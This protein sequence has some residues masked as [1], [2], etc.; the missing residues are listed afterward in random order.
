MDLTIP[1]VCKQL[2]CKDI[3]VT[4]FYGYR[5][6]PVLKK[7]AFHNGID[8]GTTGIFSSPFKGKV[9]E[10]FYNEI[11]G[12]VVTVQYVSKVNGKYIRILGQHLKKNSTVVKVGQSV[13]AGQKLA[14]IG[15]TGRS[16]GTHLHFEVHISED[17]KNWTVVNPLKFFTDFTSSPITHTLAMDKNSGYVLEVLRLQQ[18]L[19]TNLPNVKLVE[20]GLFGDN[21]RW[22]VKEFQKKYGLKVD[23]SFGPK[24]LAQMKKLYPNLSPSAKRNKG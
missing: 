4:S 16:T 13:T 2:P 15:S 7:Q 11:R 6:H 21:T 14:V 19:N 3:K 10:V 18:L 23:G 8:F 12:Y 9:T 24:S 5:L 22:A 20:D 1:K 17:G